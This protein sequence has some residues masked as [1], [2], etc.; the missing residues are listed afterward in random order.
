M[1]RDLK[2]LSSKQAPSKIQ[3]T[4]TLSAALDR[5]ESP[6]FEESFEGNSS[7][8]AHSAYASK[9]L[10]TAVSRSGEMSSPKIGAALSTLRQIVNMHQNQKSQTSSKSRLPRQIAIHAARSGVKLKDLPMPPV[11]VVLSVC[12]WTTGTFIVFLLV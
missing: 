12:K 3:S 5:H 10:E 8:A 4:S 7:M 2:T 11:D 6:S 9:L 1:L